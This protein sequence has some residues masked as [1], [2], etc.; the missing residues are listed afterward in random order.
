MWT[1]LGGAQLTG[2][3]RVLAEEACRIADRLDRLDEVLTGPGTAWMRFRVAE[4]DT[5]VTVVVDRALSEARQQAVALKAI[6]SEL[7][8]AAGSARQPTKGGGG[9]LDQLASRRAARI[10]GAEGR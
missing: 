2:A 10:A 6:V 3:H 8:Q 1:D 5:E 7:R 9:V 4:G